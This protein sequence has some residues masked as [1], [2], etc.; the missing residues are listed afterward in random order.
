MQNWY[1]CKHMHANY[2]NFFTLSC[3]HVTS[4]CYLHCCILH[5]SKCTVLSPCFALSVLK[6]RIHCEFF[7]SNA[8]IWYQF[9]TNTMWDSLT[10]PMSCRSGLLCCYHIHFLLLPSCC[11][12]A[13]GLAPMGARGV[14]LCPAP[15]SHFLT[16]WNTTTSHGLSASRLP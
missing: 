9:K 12:W 13:P 10:R 8:D 2:S 6:E 1:K 16:H 3:S 14:T 4:A 11:S 15:Q 5:A 7:S